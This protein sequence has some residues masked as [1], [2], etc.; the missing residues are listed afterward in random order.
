M[1][2]AGNDTITALFNADHAPVAEPDVYAVKTVYGEHAA[3]FL[4]KQLGIQGI[5]DF[6]R[7]RLL[8]EFLDEL[9]VDR[10]LDEQS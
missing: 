9:V 6:E 2:L 1:A 7:A 4:Y 10:L 5:A 8:D 3:R